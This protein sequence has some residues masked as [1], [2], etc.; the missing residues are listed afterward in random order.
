MSNDDARHCC[1]AQLY[2]HAGELEIKVALQLG[3]V[4]W[5]TPVVRVDGHEDFSIT[6]SDIVCVVGDV[7]RRLVRSPR[8]YLEASGTAAAVSKECEQCKFIRQTHGM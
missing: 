2:A 7:V 5:P 6:E 4:D 8:S 1:R 3:A